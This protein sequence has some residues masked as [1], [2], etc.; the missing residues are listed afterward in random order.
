MIQ[1]NIVFHKRNVVSRRIST[2]F[3]ANGIVALPGG[4]KPIVARVYDIAT[5]GM[6]FLHVNDQGI[7]SSAIKMDILIF[8]VQ[9]DDE[10]FISLIKGRVKSKELVT[11]PENKA[12]IWLFNVEFLDLDAGHRQA[13]KTC[14]RLVIN[15]SL[16]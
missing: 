8:D 14:V 15:G 12:P 2:R 1:E 13:L 6:S 5:D 9:S 4:I 10:F 16:H 3:R 7:T 11:D